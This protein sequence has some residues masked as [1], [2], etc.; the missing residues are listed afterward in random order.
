[1]GAMREAEAV[2]AGVDAYRR[3]GVDIDAGARAV[4]L[5]RRAVS[6]TH[7]PQVLAD[8]GHF[9]GFYAPEGY[10]GVLVAS[11]DGVG[12]KLMLTSIM[13][14]YRLAG[15]DIV[16]HC[17]NDILACG[18][19]PLFFLDYIAASRIVP[20]SMAEVVEGMSEACVE[21]R[22]ALIGGETAEL[23]GIYR[24]GALDVAGFIVGSVPRNRMVLGKE[25][26][27]GDIVLALPS[28][29]LHTNGYTLARKV[30]G[31]DGD[32][33][34]AR[35]RLMRYDQELGRTLGEALIE[36]HR[37]YLSEIG[38]LLEMP[39]MPI[40]G[41]AHITGGGLLDNI[42]RAL[43]EGCAVEIDTDA[44]RVPPI[45]RVI[46]EQGEVYYQ[47]M[48]RV[49]NMGLGMVLITSPEKIGTILE[50]VP[51]CAEVGRVVAHEIGERVILR[52]DGWPKGI[53]R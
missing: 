51:E 43:P 34:V 37:S 13:G 41:M 49:F 10:V 25:I 7:G 12:T 48:A 31:L 29:G 27:P 11:A 40:K 38:H 15:H 46:E 19:R 20:E 18:A 2:A 47:E 42:P 21:A 44:W 16:N 35:E 26:R 17:V 45:F 1:M 33:E 52:G 4:G 22:C 8:L 53:G 36:P 30:L 32:P 50:L 3:A 14:T 39:E 5:M 24:E 23:P 28:S 9:G 6:R